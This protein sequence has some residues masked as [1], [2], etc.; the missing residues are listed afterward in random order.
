MRSILAKLKREGFELADSYTYKGVNPLEIRKVLASSAEGEQLILFCDCMGYAIA[1][2]LFGTRQA[3]EG[4]RDKKKAKFD[5]AAIAVVTTAKQCWEKLQ[6][7]MGQPVSK[8]AIGSAIPELSLVIGGLDPGA[9]MPPLLQLA[10]TEDA[11]TCMRTEV[12]EAIGG[13]GGNE[14]AKKTANAAQSKSRLGTKE[15]DC[16]VET[17]C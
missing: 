3:S 7:N 1:S 13:H 4:M 8:N 2:N 14:E 12:D 15:V 6:Q 10:L 17:N 16:T 9:V 5:Q 11:K